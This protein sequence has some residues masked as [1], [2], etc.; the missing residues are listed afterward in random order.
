MPASRTQSPNEG[1]K[2]GVLDVPFDEG[3]P[4][5]GDREWA[6]RNPG[7]EHSLRFP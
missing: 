5:C 7:A 2:I 1:T 6:P 3:S 4:S